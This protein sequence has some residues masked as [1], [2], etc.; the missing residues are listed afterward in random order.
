MLDANR[1]IIFTSSSWFDLLI[2]MQCPL[3]LVMEFGLK[4]ILSDMSTATPTFF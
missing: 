3:F 1:F 2:I 4:S